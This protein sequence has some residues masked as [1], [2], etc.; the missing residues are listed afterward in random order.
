MKM[1]VLN[2]SDRYAGYYVV[3]FGD[4]CG[5]GFT[6]CEVA[7]LLESER[8]RDIK[9]YKIHRACPDGQMELKGVRNEV[10]SLEAGMIFYAGDLEQASGDFKRLGDLAVSV[11]P[12]CRAKAQL[13]RFADGAFATSLIYPAEYDDQFSRWLLD[14][15][16]KTAGAAEGGAGAVERYYKAQKEILESRQFFAADS[17]QQLSG[18]E[19]LAATRRAAVR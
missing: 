14:G 2:N 9:V 8:F 15:Q 4:H 11:A 18:E 10:F 3:D 13:V 1:P 12:P 17:F 7:E 5:V 19:L 6:A 16:Y